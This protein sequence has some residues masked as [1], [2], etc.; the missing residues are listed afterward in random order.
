MSTRGRKGKLQKTVTVYSNDPKNPRLPLK[1]HGEVEMLA[2]FEPQRINLKH[3]AVG[4]T[5]TQTARLAGKAADKLRISE[6]HSS[7]D[8]L[9]AELFEEDGRQAVKITLTAADKPGRFSARVTAKTNLEKPDKIQLFVWHISQDLVVDRSY[10]FFPTTL[11]E[12]GGDLFTRAMDT[13]SAPLLENKR[14]VK[15]KVSS[16]SGKPFRITDVTD[17]EGAVVGTA[18]HQG[19]DWFVHLMLV[20]APQGTRGKVML[21]TDRND[22]EVV[23]VRYS[24]RRSKR[25]P[26]ATGPG[27]KNH[28]LRVVKP[29]R[30]NPVNRAPAVGGKRVPLPE[31][32]QR[33]PAQPAKEPRPDARPL[34]IKPKRITPQK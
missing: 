22:Q 2:G 29:V 7:R 32:V 27:G 13:V 33:L 25:P 34:R 6:L 24:A 9:K 20:S 11:D 15:L 3:V 8:D 18:D 1:V 23:E 31:G 30:L 16:L 4:E 17:P 26:R 5:V 21:H 12:N 14:T 28:D 19:E 10:V